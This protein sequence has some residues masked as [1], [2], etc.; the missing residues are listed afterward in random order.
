MAVVIHLVPNWRRVLARAWTV[1]LAVA[2]ALLIAVQQMQADVSALVPAL[3]PLLDEGW[4]RI[5]SLVSVLMIP[6][7]RIVKQVT[8]AVDDVVR[9]ST[10]GE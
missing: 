10:K 1:W 5:L 6:V 3:A 7:A 9:E 8:L 2:S 4:A